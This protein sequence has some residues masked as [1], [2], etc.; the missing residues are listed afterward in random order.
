MKYSENT[1]KFGEVL[2][3]KSKQQVLQLIGHSNYH[4]EIEVW[5][6]DLIKNIF[7]KREMIL[8]FA[9]N[10]V[11]EVLI[12]D[13]FLGNKIREYIYWFQ[14]YRLLKMQKMTINYNKIFSDIIEKKYPHKKEEC[15]ALLQKQVLTTIDI[16]KLNQKIFGISKENEISNLQHRSYVKSDILQILDYQKKHKLNNSQLANHFKLSRNT[17]SKWRKIFIL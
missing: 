12:T 6:Y 11:L 17:V 13:Y 3:E 15:L 4:S 16:I 1:S 14:A 5:K 2:K 9:D 7:F 8:F 10:V